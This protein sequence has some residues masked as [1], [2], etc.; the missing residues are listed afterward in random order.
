MPEG[1]SLVI[2]KEEVQQFTGHK[3]ISVCG[4]SKIGIER[5]QGQ[6]VVS[7]KTWGKNFL[8][9]FEEFTIKI[10]LL[11]FGTY[12]IN[13]RKETEPRLSLIFDNGELN[14]YTCSIKFLEGNLNQHYDWT[15]D[16]MNEDWDPK[17]AKK[18]WN[19][20]PKK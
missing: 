9:C 16:V 14:F 2:L 12:R 18:N 20:F 3:V 8:I 10:H 17:A 1:P 4:N 19:R 7:F 6:T 15:T 11:M 13:E 5:I